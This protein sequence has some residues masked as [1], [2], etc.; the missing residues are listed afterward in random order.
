[1]KCPNCGSTAQPRVIGIEAEGTI[2]I[3]ACGCGCKFI[4]ENTLDKN[5]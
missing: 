3:C 4:L 5:D 2:L 1:M